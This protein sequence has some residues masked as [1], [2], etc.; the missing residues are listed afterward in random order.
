MVAAGSASI[1]KSVGRVI[2]LAVV[3][4]LWNHPAPAAAQHDRTGS[5]NQVAPA[6]LPGDIT[7]DAK[8]PTDPTSILDMD[9]D[10]LGKVDVKVAS[11]DIEVTSVSKQE[12]TVGRSAAAIFVITNEMIRRSGAT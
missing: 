7:P 11:M 2:A 1:I 10:Q 6:P 9:V 8:D 3:L 5:P 12:S 4:A